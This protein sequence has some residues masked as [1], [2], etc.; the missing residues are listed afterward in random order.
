MSFFEPFIDKPAIIIDIGYAYT[1]CGF[2]GEPSPFAI[3][4]TQVSIDGNEEKSIF[5][6]GKN[7]E[8]LLKELLIEFLYRIYYKILNA[9][10]RERK[11]VVIESIL[12][13][14]SVHETLSDVLFNNFQTLSAAFM[15]SHLAALYSL[16]INKG[17]VIDCGYVDCQ[18][19]PIAEGIPICGLCD[20]GDLGAKRVHR[21]LKEMII[22]HRLTIRFI[23][24]PF[25]LLII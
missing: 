21:E 2:A 5:E 11:L 20:F 9:N 24:D 22:S 19:M 17:L 15:P 1:K 10:S 25:R 14:I 23:L 18:I 12:T 3:I 4:P 16:G 13:P 8:P 7:N 6:L